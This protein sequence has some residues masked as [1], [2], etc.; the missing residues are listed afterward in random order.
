MYFGWVSSFKTCA[1]CLEKI[2]LPLLA[3]TPTGR[4]AR[5]VVS[6]GKPHSPSRALAAT[7]TQQWLLLTL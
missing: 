5:P 4:G 6:E 2:S 7:W 3:V 1:T